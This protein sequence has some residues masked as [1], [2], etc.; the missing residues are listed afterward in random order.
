MNLPHSKC[1]NTKPFVSTMKPQFLVAVLWQLSVLSEKRGEK[2]SAT[3]ERRGEDGAPSHIFY[4]HNL[5]SDPP[6]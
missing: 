6:F 4:N 3:Q 2:G 1:K 5:T